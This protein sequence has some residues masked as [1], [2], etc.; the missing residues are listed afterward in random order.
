MVVRELQVIY[1]GDIV[2]VDFETIEVSWRGRY[3]GLAVVTAVA[4]SPKV[5]PIGWNFDRPIGWSEMTEIEDN[6][7]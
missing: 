5:K 3:A 1:V 2:K 6:G 4:P 7:R